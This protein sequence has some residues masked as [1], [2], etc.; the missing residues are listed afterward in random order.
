MSVKIPRTGK[1]LDLRPQKIFG[2]DREVV[3]DAY[4][5]MLLV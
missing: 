5:V 1:L 4:P 2:Q 3:D